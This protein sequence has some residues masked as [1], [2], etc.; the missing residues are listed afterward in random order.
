MIFKMMNEGFDRHYNNPNLNESKSTAAE[1]KRALELTRDRLFN[2]HV[3]N[4][5]AYEVAY[6]DII[7]KLFPEKSWWEV[8]DCDIFQSLFND[9]DPSKT[10]DC[11]VAK[12]KPD[13]I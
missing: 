9:R 3:A 4:I 2:Q 13:V 12:L 11:I 6:Q 10:I 1:V 8:T 5:K 7:E